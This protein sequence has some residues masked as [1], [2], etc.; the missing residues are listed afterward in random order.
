MMDKYS[1]LRAAG[2]SDTEIN[3]Y[4]KQESSKLLSAGFSQ[5][6]VAQYLGAPP[7]PNDGAL[8]QL[9]TRNL[10]KAAAPGADGQAKP[11]D[12]MQAV[13]AGFGMSV[14]GLAA[15]GK[16]PDQQPT[17]NEAWYNRIAY[18]AA[19][20]A[21]DVPAMI[22]GG[23]IGGAEGAPTGPGAALTA[24]AGAFALPA[25]LRATMVDAYS[26]GEFV[27]FKDFFSRASGILLDTAKGYVT[28]L[29][30]GGAGKAAGAALG[31]AAPAV[32]NVGQMGAEIGAMVTVGAA[33]EGHVPSAQDFLDAGILLLG[34]KG[35]MKAAEVGKAKLM[36]VYKKTGVPPAQVLADAKTDPTIVQDMAAGRDIPRAYEDQVD[37]MFR[38]E[39]APVTDAAAAPVAEPMVKLYQGSPHVFDKLD[40]SKAGT[41]E[42]NSTFG[43]GAYL[44]ENDAVAKDYQRALGGAG[45]FISQNGLKW[46]VFLE[47]HPKQTFTSKAEAEKWAGEESAKQNKG[48]VYEIEVPASSLELTLDWDATLAAQ[49]PK[50]IDA[51]NS[52]SEL[53]DLFLSV[54]NKR[55]GKTLTE[56]NP[57]WKAGDFYKELASALGSDKAASDALNA[58]GLQGIKYLDGG[59]RAAGEGTRNYVLFDVSKTRV[60]SRNGEP[61]AVTNGA[62]AGAQA[63]PGVTAPPPST[64]QQV[65]TQRTALETMAKNLGIEVRLTP[66]PDFHSSSAGYINVPP[67]GKVTTVPGL[68]DSEFIFAHELGHAIMV[69][70]RGAVF[71]RQNKDGKFSFWSNA[72]LRREISNWDEFTEA[73]KEMRPEFWD[74]PALGQQKYVRTPD[75]L[76]ADTIAAVLTGKRD[77]SIL[78]PM[79][80]AVGI[81]PEGLGLAAAGDGGGMTPG[82]FPAPA[83]GTPEPGSLAEAQKTILGKVDI[84]GE[85]APKDPMTF[86]KF[87]TAALDDLTPIKRAVEEMAAGKDLPGDKD[88]YTLARELRGIYGRVQV[89]IEH[90]TLDFNTLQ[91]NGK[92]LKAILEPVKNDLD[93]LRAYAISSRAMELKDRFLVSGFDIDA[94]NKVVKE[95]SAKYE[96]IMRELV[97]YQ[98]RITAYLRDSGV[99]SDDA[100][101]AMVEANKNYVPFYRMLGDEPAK[102]GAG[103][104]LSTRNPVKLFKGSGMDIVDPIESIIKNTYTYLTLA[105]R[106][107]VAKEFYLLGKRSGMAE[108]FFEKVPPSLRATTVTDA[109][110]EA[111]LSKNGI[112]QVPAEALTVFRTVRQPLAADEIGFFTDGKWTVLRVSKEL[113]DA[114]KA[115]DRQSIGML[116]E[117][118]APPA[119]M[120]RAG[121]TISP[122]FI[123]RNFVRDQFSA[124]VN[125][126]SGFVPIYDTLRG[127]A[128]IFKQD[129][130]FQ[131]WLKSGGAN[132]TLVALDRKYIQSEIY[133]LTGKYPEADFLQKTWNVVGKPIEMLRV[134]SELIENATR[135]GEFKR[136]LD[137]SG[138]TDKAALLEAGM[139]SREITLDFARVGTKV[140]A[141]NMIA[142]FFNAGAQGIDRTMR[143]LKEDP[144]GSMAKIGMSITLPSV[145]LWLA[146]KDDSRWKE[147]PDWQ[148]DL[149]WIVMTDDHVF[150]IPKPPILGVL[151]GSS[152]ERMLDATEGK[153]DARDLKRFAMSAAGEFMLDAVPTAVAPVLEQ[154]TNHSFFTGRDLVPSFLD[155]PKMG[156]LP[157]YRYTEYTSELTKAL[158]H[159]V[160]MVPGVKDTSMASPIVIDNYLRAWTGGLGTYAIQAADYDL[161]KMGVLPDPVK[162]ADTLADIPVIKAFAVRFP[163]ATAESIQRFREDY[164]D[165]R[166]AYNTIQ[167]LAKQGDFDAWQRVQQMNPQAFVKLDAMDR[168]LNEQNMLIRAIYKNPG[169][170]PDEK[171]QLID[172]TYYNMI[173]MT[174][175][176]NQMMK[177]IDAAMPKS[178]SQ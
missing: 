94:A 67:E 115:T 79:M 35:S 112:G 8:R 41:G 14:T 56:A 157:E 127:A 152:V 173:Q 75:E 28:G 22:A 164:Q 46:D 114:F 102:N 122:D 70:R 65:M 2:F 110:M 66:G 105:D 21:G 131:N 158:G 33:L 38:P 155:D 18:S 58:A 13:E 167:T 121:T 91:I 147:I 64:P 92:S 71:G 47:G 97:D 31:K 45:Y 37:P 74:N 98:N 23:V 30:T 104:G 160:G 5:Q 24:T 68:T 175:V 117:F 17:G 61:V 111:F 171:R 178:L 49:S 11:L 82:G 139:A 174:R 53:A 148:R 55:E 149:F 113:A 15:K 119:K 135:L 88:P 126:K 166:M 176:G 93:G 103:A 138:R 57:E 44:A 39:P 125:S 143:T 133:K 60:V 3:D 48:H 150:R 145:L 20:M 29:A 177:E 6:E 32:R 120:L 137:A 36:E 34:A 159:I 140:R 77:I 83:A 156:V 72:K 51:I 96:P 86:E 90:G 19:Q 108:M 153:M 63:T 89:V 73:S 118:L 12:F 161:R 100:Y 172:A 154:L 26:K 136:A 151:F 69:T 84:G 165:R 162:P 40:L 62:T 87:Y 128:S 59:S 81:K 4:L 170:P 101:A 146:N 78:F 54:R 109:E 169:I 116:M 106:N 80:K 7:A 76:V 1:E 99:L 123:A 27:D 25:G 50:I 134:T 132:A 144:V 85:G 163:A 52:S 142:A 95:T 10:D 129:E 130:S 42:G 168:A 107:A 43:H 16:L 141:L 9:F 124:F